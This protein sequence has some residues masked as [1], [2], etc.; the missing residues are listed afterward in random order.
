MIVYYIFL[1]VTAIFSCFLAICTSFLH[2]FLPLYFLL[3]MLPL[4]VS[5]VLFLRCKSYRK[6]IIIWTLSIL[7]IITVAYGYSEIRNAKLHGSY[8]YGETSFDKSARRFLPELN[9]VGDTKSMEHRHDASLGIGFPSLDYTDEWISL[10]VTY[11]ESNFQEQLFQIVQTYTFYEKGEIDETAFW[12]TNNPFEWNG[13]QFYF[14]DL[15]LDLSMSDRS[16][17][18]V[19][20]IGFNM[21]EQSIFYLFVE[22][23][24]FSFMDAEASIALILRRYE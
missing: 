17:S 16:R 20:T 2:C 14:V 23:E 10:K 1:V 19:A 15:P 6:R 11:D 18:Y 21:D 12:A 4:A 24:E 9:S 3:M 8:F 5:V 7:F 13:Y 22:S